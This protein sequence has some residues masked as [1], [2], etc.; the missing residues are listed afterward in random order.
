MRAAIYNPYLDTLGGGERYTLSFAK[1]LIKA[2]YK[3]DIQW[4]KSPIKKTLEDRF[5][6]DLDEV[7]FVSDIGRGDGY[8]L[9]FWVSDGSIPTLRARRNILHFQVPFHDVD[10]KTLLN[11][12]KLFRISKIVC[13]SAFTKNIIDREYGVK[14]VVIYPPVDVNKIKPKRKENIILY[15]GRFSKL[16]QSKR[17][18]ILIK[19]FKKLAAEDVLDKW[20]LILAGG[21]EVGVDDNLKRLRSLAK[22]FSVSLIESPSFKELVDLYG[23]S[24]IYW[25]AAGYGIDEG[26]HPELTEHFGISLVEAMAAGCVPI[27]F[28]AGGQ[29]EIIIGGENGLLWKNIAKLSENTKKL[30]MDSKLLRS[31]SK[32]AIEDSK[33]YSNERFEKEVLEII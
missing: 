11:K 28:E 29:K 12:M 10:G 24:K 13:N 6:M 15:V 3:V 2:G 19:T 4:N 33:K 30:I 14:S 27:V 21:V 26:K 17:Q 7:S 18:D 23:K 31:I 25:S 8:E 22:G 9:C 1:V 5:G 32:K 20:Q 16:V